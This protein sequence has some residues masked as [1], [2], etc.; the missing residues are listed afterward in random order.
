VSQFVLKTSPE[1]LEYIMLVNNKS[2]CIQ[3]AK[4]AVNETG[5]SIA[6][7]TLRSSRL[8]TIRSTCRARR[9]ERVK[10]CCSTSSTWPKGMGSTR[11]MCH[12]ETWRAKWNL[13]LQQ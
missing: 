6:Q 3:V 2:Y 9:D 12:V 8:D 10:P 13:G 11:R 1:N 4:P 7:I 5:Y